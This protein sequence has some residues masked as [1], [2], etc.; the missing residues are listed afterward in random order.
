MV[1]CDKPVDAFLSKL[2]FFLDWFVTNKRLWKLDDVAFSNDDIDLSDIDSDI[3]KFFC[4]DM[5]LNVIDFNSIHVNVDDFDGNDPLTI[6]LVR[7]IAWCN[8]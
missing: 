8:R 5:G 4:D 1:K 6:V 3:V 7:L 2:D